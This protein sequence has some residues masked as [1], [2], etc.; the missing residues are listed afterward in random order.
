MNSESTPLPHPRHRPSIEQI[1][2]GDGDPRP[3]RT[4]LMCCALHIRPTIVCCDQTR[5]SACPK[6]VPSV[7][8]TRFQ[9]SSRSGRNIKVE[10]QPLRRPFPAAAAAALALLC[11]W[12]CTGGSDALSSQGNAER[13]HRRLGSLSSC[14]PPPIRSLGPAWEHG[15][16]FWVTSARSRFEFIGVFLAADL[17]SGLLI[18]LTPA[19]S[20]RRGSEM[21][22]HVASCL[23]GQM[24]PAFVLT[25]ILIISVGGC[26]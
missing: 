23:V 25:D 15:L 26:P 4:S 10:H 1:F 13:S 22:P 17:F 7:D 21:F 16:R 20:S 3:P 11:F 24:L 8:A 19:G 18:L 5:R 14:A 2:Y 12:P 6:A 9:H